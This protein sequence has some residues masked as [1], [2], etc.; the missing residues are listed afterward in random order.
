MTVFDRRTLLR[1][2]GAMGAAGLI[3]GCSRFGDNAPAAFFERLGKPIGLQ[4]YAL[5]DD[6][7]DDLA[8]AFRMV[9]EMGYGEVE[10]PSLLGSTAPELRAHADAAGVKIA[11]LHI[12]ARAFA[13]SDTLTFEGDPDAIAAI[14]GDL[15]IDQVVIPFPILPSDFALGEGEQFPSAITRTFEALGLDH[16]RASAARYNEIGAA[17]KERGL[18]LGYHN[19]NLEFAPVEGSTPWDVLVAETDPAL[20]QFQLDIGWVVTAGRDPVAALEALSG[21]LLSVHVKDVAADNKTGFYF[22]MSPTEVGSGTIDWS[23]VLPAAEAAGALHY[24]VE[25]EPPFA[26]PRP[27]A[28]AKSLAYLKA[29][30]A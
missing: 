7:H 14:A 19:H 9:A 8:G 6:I 20:V 3:G 11:S 30:E 4:M 22:G 21:R 27:E 12:P 15:G 13:P 1:G 10:L 28:A 16:W 17:M 25:Q 2:I 5:G 29:L 26:L 24:F 23:A 18:K